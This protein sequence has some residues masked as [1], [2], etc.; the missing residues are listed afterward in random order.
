[1]SQQPRERQDVDSV[2]PQ[3]LFAAEFPHS[4]VHEACGAHLESI[5]RS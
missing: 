2:S 4:T 3:L 1:M 5:A